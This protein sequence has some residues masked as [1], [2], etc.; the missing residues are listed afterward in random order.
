MHQLAHKAHKC[1]RA[2][3]ADLFAAVCCRRNLLTSNDVASTS[4]IGMFECCPRPIGQ[5]LAN[6]VQGHEPI[7]FMLQVQIPVITRLVRFVYWL[8]F[9]FY[10]NRI[11]RK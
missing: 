5:D 9:G 8:P 4:I 3:A 10:F 7:Q 11:D 1:A 6:D 2:L